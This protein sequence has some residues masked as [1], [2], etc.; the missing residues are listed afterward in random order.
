M[1]IVFVMLY[2]KCIKLIVNDKE[3]EMIKIIILGLYIYIYDID[4]SFF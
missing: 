2:K 1:R 4:M 3:G